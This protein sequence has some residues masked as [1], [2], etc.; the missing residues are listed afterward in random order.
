M[1]L[2]ADTAINIMLINETTN[3]VGNSFLVSE[4]KEEISEILDGRDG[5]ILEDPNNEESA[6]SSAISMRRNM[7]L[8]IIKHQQQLEELDGNASWKA[9]HNHR[10][11]VKKQSIDSLKS[12]NHLNNIN[13]N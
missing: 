12:A 11:A 8:N 1:L 6:S 3:L 9:A 10:L 13:N 5:S 7:N 2:G 4:R